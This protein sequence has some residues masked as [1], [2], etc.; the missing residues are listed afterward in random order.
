M[1]YLI[2]AGLMIL[3]LFLVILIELKKSLHLLYIIP[4]TLFFFSGVYFFYDSILGYPTKKPLTEDFQLLSYLVSPDET[5][6]YL[7]VL[8]F[9]ED[10][11]ISLA[12]PYSQ[13]DHK[14]LEE[15]RKMMEDGKMVEGSLKE[16]EEE[17]QTVGEN[18]GE[19]EGMGLGTEKSR[20]GMLSLQEITQYRFLQ[21][22][23][24]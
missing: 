13:E 23:T 4:I 24:N 14:S 18:W 20:G 6:I 11:P 15:G 8:T 5:E 7:W 21:R 12:I 10:Q 9:G 17:E 19:H 16:G 3:T 1:I 22:K 2:V